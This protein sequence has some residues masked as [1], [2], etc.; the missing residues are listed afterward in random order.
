MDDM[1][2]V[3]DNPFHTEL[4]P[5]IEA[6][7][8]TVL[9]HPDLVAV[10]LE[11]GTGVILATK[12]SSL[13]TG[14]AS[15]LATRPGRDF[16][17]DEVLNVIQRLD[18]AGVEHWLDGGWGVDALLGEQTRPHDDL[19]LVIPAEQLG[20]AQAALSTYRHTLDVE[21]GLPS[22]LVLINAT[23]SQLDV[24][25]VEFD[26]AGNGWQPLGGEAWARYCAAG[27]S[28]QG[29]IAGLSVRCLSADLQLWHHLGFVWDER[30]WSDMTSLAQRFGLAL[31]PRLR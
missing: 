29:T 7:G 28:G 2:P 26:A 30:H 27:L 1:D 21:P 5:A 9:G 17:S 19:D 31:P 8:K 20:Q 10:R 18:E 22:R 16:T 23:G 14:D 12:R 13:S 25:P 24:H 6:A 4:F 11:H 3:P 15:G